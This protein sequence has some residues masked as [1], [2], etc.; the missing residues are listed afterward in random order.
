M[1]IAKFLSHAGVCSRRDAE[2]LIAEGKVSVNGSKLDTPAVKVSA[3]DNIMVNGKP[4][5]SDAPARVFLHYKKSGF[6]TTHKDEKGRETMFDKLPKDMPRVISV[7]RLDLNTEGLILLTTDGD[8]ARHFE[9]P[10]T[11]L[12]RRYRVRVYGHVS[13][14]KLDSLKNG[15][16]IDGVKYGPI[17][18]FLEKAPKDEERTGRANSWLTVALAEG[19][20]REIRNVMEH[21]GLQVNRLIRV[22]YGPFQLGN[23][24]PGDVKEVPP[25]V[26]KDQLPQNFR[27]KFE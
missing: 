18:A 20:N 7:G 6:P 5:A 21:L 8:L 9:L 24:R 14:G 11:G 13:Q 27:G 15:I 25:R 3:E 19:K 1:R 23:L 26:L 4:V 12:T 17:E 10:Q 16:T 2:A 22:A